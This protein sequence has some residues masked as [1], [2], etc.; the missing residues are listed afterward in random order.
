MTVYVFTAIST[1]EVVNE[2]DRQGVFLDEEKAKKAMFKEVKEIHKDN[3]YCELV[4]EEVY[5]DEYTI[6]YENEDGETTIY[7]GYIVEQDVKEVEE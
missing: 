4:N 7:N 6:V 1:G 2:L 3:S 5:D